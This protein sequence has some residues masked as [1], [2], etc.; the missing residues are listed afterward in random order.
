MQ[1]PASAGHAGLRGVPERQHRR[2]YKV[3]SAFQPA[4]A[5]CAGS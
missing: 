5:D 3:L 2:A 1:V 4:S